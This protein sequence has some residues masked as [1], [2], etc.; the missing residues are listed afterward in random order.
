MPL[1]GGASEACDADET[2]QNLVNKVLS[3]V[4]CFDLHLMKNRIQNKQVVD[5]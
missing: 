4:V 1:C 5:V 3:F 2:V